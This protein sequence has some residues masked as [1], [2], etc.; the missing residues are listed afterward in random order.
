MRIDWREAPVVTPPVDR[1]RVA[2][3]RFPRNRNI[4]IEVEADYD[5][6]GAI[7]TAVLRL[8]E[9]HGK[10]PLYWTIFVTDEDRAELRA[11][12]QACNR[13]FDCCGIT[14]SNEEVVTACVCRH[15]NRPCGYRPWEHVTWRGVLL[16]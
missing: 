11:A 14:I 2:D 12:L 9:T 7:V 3:P 6:W 15:H 16:R 1:T 8:D 5:I 10:S 13:G 4:F